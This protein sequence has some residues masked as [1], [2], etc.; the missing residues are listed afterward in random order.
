MKTL[1]LSFLLLGI[2][3][4]LFSQNK[5]IGNQTFIFKSGE[6]YKVSPE[7]NLH[8]IDNEIVTIKLKTSDINNFIENH[9]V[10]IVR[11][12]G[13]GFFD[14]RVPRNLSALEFSEIVLKEPLVES[15]DVNTYGSYGFTPNDTQFSSQWY[16]TKIGMI[17]TWDRVRGNNCI[18]VAIIDSGLDIAH[19]DIGRGVDTYDNLWRNQGED[20][21]TDPNNP[22][23]GN[24]IDDDGNGLIDDWRGWD[25]VNFNN[26]VRSPGNSH[27]THVAGIVS[28]KLHNGRGIS[29]IGGGNSTN[30]IQLMMLGV[31]ET[32]PSS[33]AL[34]DA[35]L[36]AI[37][38]GA[39][40]I[41]LSLSV[42][43]TNA[44]D[45]A[46]QTAINNGIPVICASG[47]N[48]PSLA[49]SYPAT[50][51]NVIAVGSTNSSDQKSSFS[52][53]GT[54]LFIAAPGEQIRSTRIGNT[55]GDDSG[56]S[57]AAPQV[58]AIVGLIR[59]IN[60]NL[61][62]QQI[63]DVL[64]NTADKVGG[65]NYNWDPARPGHSRELG[66][67]RLNANAAIQQVLPTITG[68]NTLCTTNSNYSLSFI[69]PNSIITWSVSPI[70]YFATNGGANTNGTGATATVRAASNFA[71]SATI[72]FIIQGGCTV[73]SRT[74]WVGTPQISNQRVDGSSYY[75]PTYICPGNHW[76]QVTP[77]GTTNNANWT[78]QSG[79]PFHVTP[80]YLD[81][82]MYSNVSSIAITA[83]ASNVCGTGA[84]AAFYL[85][86]KTW[87]CPSSYY[88]I[89]AYPNPASQELTVST[90]STLDLSDASL[91]FGDVLKDTPPTPSRAVL[92][93]EQGKTVCEGQLV[94][95]DLKLNLRGLKRGLYY[96]HIYVDDQIYKEQILVD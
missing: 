40:V 56:T 22:T 19:E 13:N 17:A 20:N 49:V 82:T 62:V 92:I 53:F 59:S 14:I 42:A 39:D 47:N 2:S 45:N 31:G 85:M 24:G 41:Q 88:S 71:G 72:S 84:N 38:N 83:N 93:D 51:P 50:N 35:I 1:Y 10:S 48:G 12:S 16:L 94:G 5:K 34:D 81:F 18:Q 67:G 89:T 25:F 3:F 11:E 23:T 75:G 4:S 90:V 95:S 46:I 79:V 64:S 87:G 68:S 9:R 86:R 37:Q 60:P 52:N 66:F 74:I 54:E 28:A 44:I 57:F 27:G 6:W 30:G 77:I 8:K 36:Y 78:V 7:G 32:A 21:W 55:Y 15:I 43:Q 33:A 69:P 26:D 76:L 91:L 73:I 63:R 61:T 70:G 96:I 58:S 29:G 80:N 65:V